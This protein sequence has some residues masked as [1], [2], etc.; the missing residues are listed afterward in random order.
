MFWILY[1]FFW[2]IPRRP[3]FISNFRHVLNPVFFLLGDSPAFEFYFKL[4]LCSESCI[5]SF[6]RFPGVWILSQTFAMF[7]IPYFF[8]WVNPRRLNFISKFRYVLNPVFIFFWVIPRLLNF[9]P[10][11]F[12]TLL[13]LH[14]WCKYRLWKLNS[15]PKRPHIQR[16]SRGIT[17]KRD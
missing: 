15:V 8:F 17:Q 11:R 14:R 10:R 5:F 9:I 2:V 16:R 13:Y 6:G 3:N 1:F 12:G 7:W 4:S